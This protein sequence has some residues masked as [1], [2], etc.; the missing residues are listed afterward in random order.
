MRI[1]IAFRI[2]LRKSSKPMPVKRIFT[3]E[4]TDIIVSEYNNQVSI[5]A[6]SRNFDISESAIKNLLLEQGVIT[7]APLSDKTFGREGEIADLYKSGDTILSIAAKFGCNRRYISGALLRVGLSKRTHSEQ[8]RKYYVDESF[9]DEINTE[10]K[11]YFL[12]LLY[13][14][15]YNSNRFFAIGLQLRDRHILEAFKEVLQYEGPLHCSPSNQNVCTLVVSSKKMC[16][17]L[18]EIGCVRKKSLVLTFPTAVPKILVHHFLRGYF[19]GDG[20][21]TI[22]KTTKQP[23]IGM[24]GS[25]S[26]INSTS[27]LIAESLSIK[28]TTRKHCVSEGILR[29]YICG[30]INCRLLGDYLY[31]SASLFLARKRAIIDLVRP[32]GKLCGERNPHSKLT[33]DTVIDIRGKYAKSFSRAELARQY[34]VSLSTIDRVVNNKHWANN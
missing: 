34:G 24:L 28:V 18:S 27:T 17:R 5:K 16:A 10:A 26:F 29:C 9:F 19:D 13:A 14:D 6:L 31:T 21:V 11:A 1:Q 12:G 8:Q 32:K 3:Q 20:W 25:D 23:T 4:E 30:S 2:T 7:R 33:K 22:G 15:G